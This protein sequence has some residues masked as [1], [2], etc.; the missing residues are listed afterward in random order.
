MRKSQVPLIIT[1]LFLA[2]HFASADETLL[3][4]TTNYGTKP[5]VTPPSDSTPAQPTA[6]K[7]STPTPQT[8]ST[9]TLQ[10]EAVRR[11]E[12]RV[13][14]QQL[15][16]DGYKAYYDG[17]YEAA[18]AKFEKAIKVMPRAEATEVDYNRALHG[19]GDSYA[20]LADDALRA[21]QNDKAK[22]Y[23][24]KALEYDAKNRAAEN[25]IVKLKVA[26]K[27]TASKQA[28]A[29]TEEK[30]P[31]T[32]VEGPHPDRAPEFVAKQDQVRKLFREARLL[33]NSGQQDEAEKRY[34]QILL[35]DHYNEDAYLGL[36][37]VNDYRLKAATE[38]VDATRRKRLWEVAEAWIPAPETVVKLPAADKGPEPITVETAAKEKIE[39]KLRTIKF[40]ELNFREASVSDVVKFLSDES[41]KYDPDEPKEGV[42][43]VLGASLLGAMSASPAPTP[44]PAPG[45]EAAAAPAAPITSGPKPIT[46]SLRKVT[47][48]QAL[49]YV[50]SLAQL[51]YRLDP[52]AVVITSP[53]EPDTA[54]VTRP[55]KVSP[56]AIKALLSTP[57][58]VAPP[59]PAGG[60]A[61]V[62]P[63]PS[64]PAAGTPGGDLKT[65]FLEAGVPFPSGSSV[66]YFERA[67]TIYVRNTVENLEV[68]ER[69]LSTFNVI[70]SQVEIEAKFI[71][72]SQADLDELSFQW[73]MGQM[74]LNGHVQ[75][76][77]GGGLS[78]TTSTGN[79]NS[80]ASGWI[81]QGLRGAGILRGN[82]IDALLFGNAASRFN[83][84]VGSF[85]G[86]LNN[87]TVQMVVN[88]LAQKK[89]ADILS[90]PKVTTI[91]GQ[92]AQMRV[93]QEF[94]YPSE[95]SQ[96]TVADSSMP[97][98]SI[99]TAFKTREVGV[100]L[101]VTPTVGA[102][103][104]TIN[105]SIVPEVSAFQGMLDYSPDPINGFIT[106]G[107]GTS[108]VVLPLTV[109][110]KI[111]QPLFETR[112]LTTSVVIWDG[113]TV[114]L[115]GLIREEV[116]KID[117]KI[118]FLGDIPFVGRLF[119][120]KVDN[121]TKRNLLVFVTARLI[122]PAGNPIHKPEPVSVK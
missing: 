54:M 15:I 121:R 111:W 43:I 14:G 98:P 8:P 82:P 119:R 115:G 13:V 44:A 49:K 113:Q 64:L 66:T 56:D 65:F 73:N 71:E 102:D 3:A 25:I 11:Q 53:D 39:R 100:I 50:T 87:A 108:F 4:L 27:D 2:L 63:L 95:Y 81:T 30:K 69:V 104:N 32:I 41:I 72:V 45:E 35:I 51:K 19:L 5:R 28:K 112:N 114:V 16:N 23:A 79:T 109:S 42:N 29:R 97:T 68:F 99:P 96:P 9:Q 17:K 92:Q 21:N 47:M 70:P 118:P 88:A 80:L 37:E 7:P 116:T 55:Y 78:T 22:Q 36:Q 110:Y 24:T 57:S 94:I 10:E 12:A 48:E 46:L 40:P 84:A 105:L 18:I 61:P 31:A 93:V 120:S 20:R 106:V 85:S 52:N 59:S 122:D 38:G 90:A 58:S 89:S 76:L 107:Q 103:G 62:G 26:E 33:M 34:K 77:T 117:D 101:N 1:T 75:S 6:P 60:L 67:S 83:D 86:V 74:N 91:S